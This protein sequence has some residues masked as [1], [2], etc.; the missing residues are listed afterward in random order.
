IITPKKRESSGIFCTRIL[1]R[2]AAIASVSLLLL[3]WGRVRALIPALTNCIDIVQDAEW[4][5]MSPRTPGIADQ[6]RPVGCVLL[7][8]RRNA[9]GAAMSLRVSNLHG[10]PD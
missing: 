1:P 2:P 6:S 4:H 8:L 7:M 10:T 9:A 5:G 3:R